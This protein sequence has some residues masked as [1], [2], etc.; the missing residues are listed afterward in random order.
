MPRK[1]PGSATATGPA[2][3]NENNFSAPFTKSSVPKAAEKQP[4]ETT[5]I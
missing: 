2:K 3:K 1:R 5:T 4:A